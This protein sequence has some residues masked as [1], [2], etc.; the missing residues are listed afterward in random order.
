[1]LKISDKVAA[2]MLASVPTLPKPDIRERLDETG[3][4]SS[5]TA[6]IGITLE[7]RTGRFSD[8]L[9]W[10]EIQQRDLNQPSTGWSVLIA[11]FQ[12]GVPEDTVLAVPIPAPVD[13]AGFVHGRFELRY[14]LYLDFDGVAGDLDEFSIATPFIVDR[15]GP[16]RAAGLGNSVQPPVAPYPATVPTPITKAFLDAN[17]TIEVIV[18]PNS[19]TI[20]SGQYQPGD[21]IQFYLSPNLFPQDMYKIGDP[22]PMQAAPGTPY[23]LPSSAYTTGGVMNLFHVIT[24]KAGN[25]S[26][27]SFSETRQV[28]LSDPPEQKDIFFPLAPAPEPVPGPGPSTDDL[29]N[30]ADY[31]AG[32]EAH[33]RTYLNHL[34]IDRIEIKWGSQPYSLLSAPFT[35]FPLIFKSGLNDLIKA[36]YGTKE[37]PQPTTVLYRIVQGTQTFESLPKIVK[38]DLSVPG[39]VNPGEPGTVN[40]NLKPAQFT[41]GGPTPVLNTLNESDAGLPVTVIIPLW[42]VPPPMPG[43]TVTVVRP[44]GTSILPPQTIGTQLPGEDLTFTIPWSDIE[45]GGNTVQNFRY[46]VESL[47]TSNPNLGP[48]TAVTVINAVTQ[49]LPPPVFRR[50]QSG[51]LTCSSLGPLPQSTPP[52]Y[53]AQVFVAGDPRMVVGQMLNLTVRVYRPRVGPVVEENQDVF[54]QM[55]TEAIRLTGFTFTIP[56]R[57]LIIT[58]R[59][60]VAVATVS[61][62]FAGGVIGRGTVTV[63]ARSVLSQSYCDLTPV[64]EGP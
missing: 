17:P 53:F 4:I 27:P 58:A 33:V 61:T 21:M 59:L 46:I 16:Y 12:T 18:P 43:Q 24:D 50:L 41:G 44:D 8:E 45:P 48:S 13:T 49:A 11:P 32:I 2:V 51:Q 60:G 56:F 39:P 3:I 40:P 10:I 37:G 6:D 28:V 34:P 22:V 64:P 36:E 47:T 19:Y 63:N 7:C 52:D 30:I 54:P 31:V 35:T 62:M 57:P 9:T 23:S 25:P 15:I 55:I 20:A 14:A 42:T 38:V 1:M 5:A 26:L 29:L